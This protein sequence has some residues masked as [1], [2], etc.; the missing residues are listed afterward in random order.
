MD[1]NR[2]AHYNSL[3]SSEAL[4]LPKEE[5]L[6]ALDIDELY[7]GKF[8]QNW[9]SNSFLAKLLTDPLLR[10]EDQVWGNGS[11]LVIG[12]FVHK[13]ILEPEK[14]QNF[15][16]SSSTHRSQN[17][18]KADLE[19]SEFDTWM[20]LEKDKEKWMEFCQTV[21]S[22]PEV[23]AI[24][25]DPNNEFEVPQIAM[26]N[27]LPIKG[28]CDIINHKTKTIIDLKTTS[29]LFGFQDKVDEWNYNMQ[30]TI[31]AKALYPDYNF[32]F[33]AVDKITCGTGVFDI[34]DKQ[35]DIGLRKLY[36]C[37]NLYKHYHAKTD[38]TVYYHYL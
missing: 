6:A 31:Y 8:G 32:R 25:H 18:Y 17:S 29:N 9:F 36:K 13:A 12:N 10:E 2:I 30:A 20:F 14:A 38:D 22:N 1:E 19:A 4:S 7:Y 21:L 5:I 27:G 26:F 34:S 35:F 16:A 15:P 37:I 23:K 24:L 11:A 3:S 28:K 33:V